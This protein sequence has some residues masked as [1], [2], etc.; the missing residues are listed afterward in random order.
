MIDDDDTLKWGNNANE[1]NASYAADGYAR[2]NGI[3][4]LITTFGV[5]ELATAAG[6][7]GSFAEMLPVIH[8]VGTPKT[9]FQKE[10]TIVHHSLGTGN[11]DMFRDMFSKICAATANITTQ[12]PLRDIDRVFQT[13]IVRKRPGYIGI[14]LD[15][16]DYKVPAINEPLDFSIPKNPASTQQV[17]LGIV[18]DAIK[19]SKRPIILVD[20]CIHRYGLEK[21]ANEFIKQSQ[22]PTYVTP[23]G[24]GIVPEEY[25]NYRG[26]YAG[27]LTL[28]GVAKEVELA[29]LVIE[30]GP[31]K[32]DTNTG[33]FTYCYDTSKTISLHTFATDVFHA[34]YT[35]VGIA[36][37]LPLLTR[38]IAP[39]PLVDLGPRCIPA[40][41]M[42]GST[43]ITHNYF[44]NKVSDY[45]VPNSIV[46]AE[47]GSAEFA[48]FNMK[49][50]PG[51]TFITQVLWSAIGYSVGAALGAGLADRERQVYLFCGDG[52][53]QMSCQ[54]VSVM[55]HHG[56]TP[57][58]FILNNDGYLME[59]LIH[60]L[61]RPYNN[62]QM[63][64]Y[65]K[66]LEYFGCKLQDQK[67]G[68]QAKVWTRIEFEAAMKNVSAQPN[69]IHF[70][71]VVMPKFDAPRELYRLVDQ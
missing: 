20:A 7:A 50:P 51:S 13:S 12:D 3:G 66:T 46:V 2:I 10:G 30:L 49:A 68:V 56:L 67:V 15:L 60:G 47:T 62:F 1:L 55:L 31:I 43:K 21:E 38:S 40:P 36:E 71:E 33:G 24:K 63:W 34:T 16:I 44:W 53:F 23:M 48:S 70:I 6:V 41:I 25:D 22:F 32:S 37:F 59:K 28:E 8:I 45:M 29:D 9:Q 52:S 35:K 19:A 58:I 57:V 27:K 5:G 11:F 39:R 26:V 4:C 65:S 61:H 14:P 69:K 54:E 17:L 64:E 42:N 18:M